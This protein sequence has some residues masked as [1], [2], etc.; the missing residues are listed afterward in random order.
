MDSSFA[1]DTTVTENGID[2]FGMM[3]SFQ[4]QHHTSVL[5]FITYTIFYYAYV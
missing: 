5:P 1:G 4:F 3:S 2:T